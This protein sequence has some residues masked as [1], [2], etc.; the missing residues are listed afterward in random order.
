M[1][2]WTRNPPPEK[3]DDCMRRYR[4]SQAT[5]TAIP[6]QAARVTIAH[7]CSETSW[8]LNHSFFNFFWTAF[9]TAS[10]LCKPSTESPH[11]NARGPTLPLAAHFRFSPCFFLSFL[12]NWPAPAAPSK[13]TFLCLCPFA[14]P[15][16]ACCTWVA[17][18]TSSVA[19]RQ[20]LPGWW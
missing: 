9:R 2:P 3:L 19:C 6:I 4:A 15:F 13:R 17:M 18:C 14:R 11:A 8:P 12:P 1:D 5:K 7:R 16:S 20:E 10:I